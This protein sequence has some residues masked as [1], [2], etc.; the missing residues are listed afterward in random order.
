MQKLQKN[1]QVTHLGR[2]VKGQEQPRRSFKISLN[3]K[4]P[5]ELILSDMET[6]KSTLRHAVLVQE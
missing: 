2:D 6:Y 3:L 1:L 4:E 5:G